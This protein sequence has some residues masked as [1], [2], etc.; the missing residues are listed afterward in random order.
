LLL[1]IGDDAASESALIAKPERIPG[2][3]YGTLVPLAQALEERQLWVGATAVYRALLNA[4]LA[5]AYARAY[6]HAAR[7]WLR[8]QAMA[9]PGISL[10]PLEPHAVFAD[11][12][13]TL[14]AR[15]VRFWQCVQDAGQ[16]QSDNL[17]DAD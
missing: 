3:D 15:K 10:A 9:A 5:R 1:D 7:Y 8:L 14:H 2:E 4:I 16:A 6:G 13:R 12:V 11:T 17:E